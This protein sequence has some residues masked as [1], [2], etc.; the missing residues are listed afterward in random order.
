MCNADCT[1]NQCDDGKVNPA[2]GEEC[3]DGLD[4]HNRGD[5]LST[6]KR[7]SCGD[8][9]V[10]DR[11]NG[12]EQCDPGAPGLDTPLCDHDCT[13][14]LCGDGIVNNPHG[15][16]CDPNSG[17]ADC[18]GRVCCPSDCACKLESDC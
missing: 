18:P 16:Q 14:P 1:F 12:I 5:C 4:N 9:F 15:E 8:G 6:C 10:H 13:R 7:A 11:G 2:A 3:D 17:N